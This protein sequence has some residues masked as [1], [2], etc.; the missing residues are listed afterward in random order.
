MKRTS[1]IAALFL[2]IGANMVYWQDPWLWR[3]F[4]GFLT[5][6]DPTGMR[7][8]R[9]MERRFRDAGGDM[10]MAENPWRSA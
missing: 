2:F 10:T 6:G 4:Y 7:E 8:G 1:V 9:A 5:S 3:N